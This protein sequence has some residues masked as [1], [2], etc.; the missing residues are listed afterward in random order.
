MD[1]DLSHKSVTQNHSEQVKN[2]IRRNG[3]YHYRRRIPSDLVKAAAFGHKKG[4]KTPQDTINR[5]LRTK[6]PQVARRRMAIEDAK[7]EEEFES[8]RQEMMHSEN[9]KFLRRRN[10]SEN[11][12]RKFSSLSAPERRDF[13]FC[14]FIELE[15]KPRSIN[16]VAQEDRQE[17]LERLGDDLTALEG[18]NPNF[19]PV[20]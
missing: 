15:R 10:P 7:A 9:E 13:I 18:N 4:G 1:S 19:M 20:D 14:L 11:D 12:R 8:L 5:S 6:D 2:T 16:G 3:T 17:T